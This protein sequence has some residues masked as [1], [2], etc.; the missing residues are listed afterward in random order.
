M[1]QFVCNMLRSFD[2]IREDG[3]PILT[4]AFVNYFFS[5]IFCEFFYFTFRIIQ[6]A[7][8]LL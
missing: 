8:V 1:M 4:N 3:V 6:I 7:F 2:F 5:N